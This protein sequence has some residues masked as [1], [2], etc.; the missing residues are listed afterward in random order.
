[1]AIIRPYTFTGI[2]DNPSFTGR[3]DSEVGGSQPIREFSL[4][5]TDLTVAGIGAVHHNMNQNPKMI[6]IWY[7]DERIY[8]TEEI[9]SPDTLLIYLSEFTPLISSVQVFLFF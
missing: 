2:I 7:K 5:Q 9:Y 6:Q 4:S 3:I 8:V 1:M